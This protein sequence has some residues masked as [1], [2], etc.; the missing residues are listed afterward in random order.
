MIRANFTFKGL[1]YIILCQSEDKMEEIFKKFATKAQ[2]EINRI[3]FIYNG[4]KIDEKLKVNQIINKIDQSR[5][6]INILANEINQSTIIEKSFKS[7]EIICPNCFNNILININDYKITLYNCKNNHTINNISLKDYENTQNIDISKIICNKC[8]KNKS[9]VFKNE[10]YICLNCTE[11]LCSLCKSIHDQNHKII[12][13]EDKNNYCGND[14]DIFIK[15][16]CKC[17]KNVCMLCENEH[18]SHKMIY[19]GDMLI[20]KEVLINEKNELKNHIDKLE[21]NFENIYCNF[22]NI[23][24]NIKLYYNIYLDII[25]NYEINKKN[26]YLL[27][28]I[29]EFKKY[30]NNVYQDINK[31]I[32]ESN[33]NIKFS[34]IM[35]LYNKINNKE[36]KVDN[37]NLNKNNNNIIKNKDHKGNNKL[38]K[39]SSISSERPTKNNDKKKINTN[40][41]K[42]LSNASFNEVLSPNESFKELISRFESN[43]KELPKSKLNN[44]E[45]TKK[46][47]PKKNVSKKELMKKE[48]P[49]KELSKREKIKKELPVK[50]LPIKESSKKELPKKE[51]V[52]NEFIQEQYI[53]DG[54]QKIRIYPCKHCGRKFIKKSLNIHSSVCLSVFGKKKRSLYII[55]KKI[56][57][58]MVVIYKKNRI[59]ENKKKQLKK[60]KQKKVISN[61]K[62]KSIGFKK[63]LKEKKS[64]TGIIRKDIAIFLPKSF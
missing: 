36:K 61:W 51:L 8:K 37:N 50:E 44:Q 43:K 26:Y 48:L 33:I 62:K 41:S 21:E 15:Y 54:I 59:L 14:K 31:I 9:Q 45:L 10:F 12:N 19:L 30:N 2:I 17:N 46:E 42:Q 39:I 25:N 63:F 22:K 16:C 52:K 4:N 49:I 29:N 57:N 18:R 20:K 64:E 34:Y 5:E 40:N 56:I 47:L 53:F 1:S 11:N 28:N 32:K 58:N 13:Y 35:D 23:M 24:D 60:G 3:Y 55:E 27:Q 6:T 38:D 7:K